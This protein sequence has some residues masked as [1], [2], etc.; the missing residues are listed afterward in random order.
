MGTDT[1]SS[2]S[3]LSKYRVRFSLRALLFVMFACAVAAG[4]WSTYVEP[5][6]RQ[7][8]GIKAIQEAGGLYASVGA[9]E[10]QLPRWLVTAS[11][12]KGAFCRVTSADFRDSPIET[13][14]SAVLRWVGQ[15]PHLQSLTLD[16]SQLNDSDMDGIRGMQ[17]LKHLSLRYTKVS[18]ETLHIVSTLPSLKSLKLTGTNITDAGFPK[19][20]ELKSLRELYVRWTRVTSN[21]VSEFKNENPRCEIYFHTLAD[22]QP[23]AD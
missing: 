13:D 12:G 10:N 18:D 9:E 6:R 7:S 14:G 8:L 21:A 15:M 16:N 4:V 2:P 11:L 17:R 20:Q 19:L 3:S 1:L 5:F 23:S 22:E